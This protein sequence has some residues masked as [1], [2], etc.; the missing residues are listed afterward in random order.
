MG[1]ETS[2]KNANFI[3]DGRVARADGLRREGR[4]VEARKELDEERR[5]LDPW[6]TEGALACAVARSK[7]ERSAGV[8]DL[9]LAILMEAAPLAESCG[10]DDLRARFH[11][12]L[13]ATYQRMGLADKAWVEYTAAAHY[14]VLA[15]KPYDAGCAENNVALLV[16]PSDRARAYGHLESARGHF[17][18]MPVKL[19]EVDETEARIRLGG[20]ESGA[21]LDLALG[22][23]Q[24]FRRTGETALLLDALPTLI[25]AS[26]DHQ[27]ELAESRGFAGD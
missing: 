27:A 3:R 5:S 18:G 2:I 16:A 17:S 8:L 10:S 4:F 19:A 12:G 7:V 25:K 22:A 13:G 21:A 15:G 1:D 23:V 24:V 9:A 14:W 11:H 6:D 26:A 20:R